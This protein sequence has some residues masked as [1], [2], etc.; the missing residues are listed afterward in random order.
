MAGLEIPSFLIGTSGLIAV[1]SKSMQIAR[2]VR[3][4]RN[5]PD[6]L[7]DLYNK[8]D[9]ECATFCLW[10]EAVFGPELYSQNGDAFDADIPDQAGADSVVDIQRIV[11]NALATVQGIFEDTR[12]IFV[13]MGLGIEPPRPIPGSY[14]SSTTKNQAAEKRHENKKSISSALTTRSKFFFKIR[15]WKDAPAEKLDGLHKS[16]VYWNTKLNQL[17]GPQRSIAIQTA[18]I[19]RVLSNKSTQ[20]QLV[21]VQRANNTANAHLSTAAQFKSCLILSDNGGGE[22]EPKARISFSRLQHCEAPGDANS[23]SRRVGSYSDPN[24]HGLTRVLVEWKTAQISLSPDDHKIFKD[25]LAKLSAI[26]GLQ[27]RPDGLRTLDCLGWTSTKT[28]L[29]DSFGLIYKV[30][31]FADPMAA[32]L[33]LTQAYSAD[34]AFP[35]LLERFQLARLLSLS[36][37]TYHA[38]GWLHKAFS[39][40]NILIFRTQEG[41]VDYG[42]PYVSGFEYSR[43]TEEYSLPFDRPGKEAFNHAQHPNV[44]KDPERRLQGYQYRRSYDVYSFGIILLEIACWRPLHKIYTDAKAK[45]T[46]DTALSTLSGIVDQAVAHR[47]G[48]IYQQVILSCFHWDGRANKSD[49]EIEEFY[50]AAV[51]KLATCHCAA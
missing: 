34:K 26:L 3:D 9:A 31:D 8:F 1:V 23:P 43:P 10:A 5:V 24:D 19:S 49:N 44:A 16:L 17:I 13:E 32:P 40:D 14:A 25:R 50:F 48:V 33:S 41:K 4:M 27:T 36:L 35:T 39:S 51:Q 29:G 45:L 47:M 18:F 20:L 30:P 11:Y 12:G 7:L 28:A 15:T 2:A 46:T 42:K 22:I 38:M 21:S 37:M 6:E